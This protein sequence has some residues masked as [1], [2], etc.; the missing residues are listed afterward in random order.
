MEE[1]SWEGA[2]VIP[3]RQKYLATT[4][5]KLGGVKKKQSNSGSKTVAFGRKGRARNRAP[6]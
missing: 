4:A 5:Y 6:R 2:I 1:I 3:L